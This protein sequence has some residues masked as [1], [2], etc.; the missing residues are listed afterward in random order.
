MLNLWLLLTYFTISFGYIS[1]DFNRCKK[2]LFVGLT[3]IDLRASSQRKALE[4]NLK[5]YTQDLK[6]KKKRLVVYGKLINTK[7]DIFINDPGTKDL[8]I[9]STIDTSTEDVSNE[10]SELIS[11]VTDINKEAIIILQSILK[12]YFKYN[13]YEQLNKKFEISLETKDI[14]IAIVR[15]VI[16]PTLIHDTFQSFFN[17]LKSIH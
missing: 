10:I 7:K 13:V 3:F 4:A 14:I 2:K 5:P 1:I 16:I 8:I 11:I 9:H 12:E 17:Y 15:N 6:R